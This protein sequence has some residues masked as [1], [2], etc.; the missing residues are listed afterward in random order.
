M[1]PALPYDAFAEHVLLWKAAGCVEYILP[2]TDSQSVD[3]VSAAAT[4]SFGAVSYTHLRAH[5][6]R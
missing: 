2:C 6:T 1:A 3:A 5:E 4:Q